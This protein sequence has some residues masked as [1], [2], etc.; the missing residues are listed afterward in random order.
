MLRPSW[1]VRPGRHK[2]FESA[3]VHF[4]D[5][6][7]LVHANN[8]AVGCDGGLWIGDV[9]GVTD[10]KSEPEQLVRADQSRRDG[11]I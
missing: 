6:A 9:D 1:T 8:Q 3:R 2:V 7:F 4:G 5:G 10:S 11:D